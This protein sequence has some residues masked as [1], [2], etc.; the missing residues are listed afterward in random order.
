MKCRFLAFGVQ[1]SWNYKYCT[2]MCCLYLQSKQDHCSS[3]VEIVHGVGGRLFT[4]KT[5][6]QHLLQLLMFYC[7]TW[8]QLDPR[9]MQKS[10]FINATSRLDLVIPC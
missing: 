6:F 8:E 10:W 1:Q 2:E 4:Y 3:R 9:V 5:G 7:Q